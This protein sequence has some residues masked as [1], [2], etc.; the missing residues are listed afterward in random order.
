M[1]RQLPP[2]A[3]SNSVISPL[4]G[5]AIGGNRQN[6]DTLQPF[7]PQR[8]GFGWTLRNREVRSKGFVGN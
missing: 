1:M 7:F 2:V 4:L 6:G 8:N 3:G 5:A